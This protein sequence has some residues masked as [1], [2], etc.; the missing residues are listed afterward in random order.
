MGHGW[1]GFVVGGL[2]GDG[3]VQ[4]HDVGGRYIGIYLPYNLIL[5][6]EFIC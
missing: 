1:E 5:N 2:L 3:S 4:F 6:G